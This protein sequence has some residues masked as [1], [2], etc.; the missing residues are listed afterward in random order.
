MG[1]LPCWQVWGLATLAQPLL[2]ILFDKGCELPT[3]EPSV[4]LDGGSVCGWGLAIVRLDH[5]W[6]S[7]S[8]KG[9]L[10]AHAACKQQDTKSTT[11]QPEPPLAGNSVEKCCFHFSSRIT[12]S[13]RSFGLLLFGC[14]AAHFSKPARSGAPPVASSDNKC[15]RLTSQRCG[16]PARIVSIGTLKPWFAIANEP[17]PNQHPTA[18]VR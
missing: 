15:V 11:R 6:S 7:G 3:Q 13:S 18:C 10:C 5:N 12:R 4:L 1:E 9:C 2:R 8:A 14:P 16:L 17:I